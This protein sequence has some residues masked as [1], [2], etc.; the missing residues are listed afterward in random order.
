M[1]SSDQGESWA[2]FDAWNEFQSAPDSAAA[3]KPA[4]DDQS[5]PQTTSREVARQPTVDTVPSQSDD[6]FKQPAS[7]TIE[8]FADREEHPKGEGSGDEGE[9][10]PSGL[11]GDF[12]RAWRPEQTRIDKFSGLIVFSDNELDVLGGK[13]GEGGSQE[14]VPPSTASAPP[15]RPPPPPATTQGFS[16][17]NALVNDAASPS[18][19][20]VETEDDNPCAEILK[21]EEPQKDWRASHVGEDGMCRPAAAVD[22]NDLEEHQKKT[23]FV[24]HKGEE[25]P[26][27]WF[28]DTPLT[29]VKEAILCACD[30]MM[31]AGFVL[32]EVLG[33]KEDAPD[34]GSPRRS[35][36]VLGE[37]AYHFEE[38][39][40]L[41]DGKVYL[42]VEG[43]ERK[44]LDNITGDRW[45]RLKVTIEPVLH[46]ESQKAI[47]RMKRGTNLLK[48]TRYG[49]PH[50]RQFQLSNDM[51]RLHWYSGAKS[52]AESLVTI[53]DIK[54]LR[55]GQTTQTFLHYKLPLLEHLSFSVMYGPQASKTLDLTCKDEFEFDHWVTGLKALM[56]RAKGK[57]ISKEQLLQHSRRFRRALEKNE[58]SIKL[59]QLPEVKE[60]GQLTLDECIE[61]ASNTPDQL[62]KKLDRLSDRLKIV[63]GQICRID[64][65]SA[66]QP[67]LDISVLAGVGPAYASVYEDVSAME[68]EEMESFRMTQLADEVTKLLQQARNDLVALRTANGGGNGAPPAQHQRANET[69]ALTANTDGDEESVGVGSSRPSSSSVDGPSSPTRRSGSSSGVSA[70][71]KAVTKALDQ[72]LWKAEVDLENVEDMYARYIDNQASSAPVF[73]RSLVELQSTMNQGMQRLGD[74]ISNALTT[75][76]GSKP[77]EP[78]PDQNL[79]RVY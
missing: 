18:A 77:Q 53:D 10:P 51:N 25:T 17:R 63:Q 52:K 9:A 49:Y 28:T 7:E 66:G 42:L 71:T 76:F 54:E 70:S 21:D 26:V 65:H 57:E 38:F 40:R 46:V 44:D 45:R 20:L 5:W 48:H 39:D 4:T 36:Y 72:L 60:R 61:I 78:P 1:S 35:P 47:D 55:L 24:I 68:D 29:D 59:S 58:V 64:R 62:E 79:P 27:S 56:Y 13:K 3:A 37:D 8:P 43:E 19:P 34:D 15:S 22:P 16:L 75:W 74:D 69:D 14:A 32:R 6:P 33:T 2:N 23:I 50:L 30:A 12:E 11:L 41:V 73:Y 67:E 31:D